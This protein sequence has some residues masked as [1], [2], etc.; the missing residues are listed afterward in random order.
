MCWRNVVWS[1][2]FV[3]KC[4]AGVAANRSIVAPALEMTSFPKSALHWAGEKEHQTYLEIRLN[5]FYSFVFIVLILST[6]KLS[7]GAWA[8][9][10]KLHVLIFGFWCQALII[11]RA[12]YTVSCN[13]AV[14]AFLEPR[15]WWVILFHKHPTGIFMCS[16]SPSCFL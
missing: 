10:V 14:L 15:D 2:K 12:C 6:V 7:N 16:N 13:R 11:Y 9:S 8:F 1:L 3:T 5:H 4:F